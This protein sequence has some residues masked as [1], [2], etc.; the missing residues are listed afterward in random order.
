MTRL[1]C[2]RVGFIGCG[3]IARLQALGYLDHPRAELTAV[4]DQDEALVRQRRDEWHARKA[5]TDYMQLLA[6]R[7]HQ[8]EI[9]RRSQVREL[10]SDRLRR[11]ARALEVLRQR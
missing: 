11:H 7:P 9:R 3:R 4:C 1:D 6:A 2:V 10:G 5:Y 8:L